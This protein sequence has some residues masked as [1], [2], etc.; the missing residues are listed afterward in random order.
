MFPQNVYRYAQTSEALSAFVEILTQQV[1]DYGSQLAMLALEEW[2]KVEEG[3]WNIYSQCA[4][5]GAE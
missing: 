3:V 5:W 2:T 1:S 4:A